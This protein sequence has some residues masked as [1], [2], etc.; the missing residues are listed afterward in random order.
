MFDV[1][2]YPSV[3]GQQDRIGFD[4]AVD[5]ALRVEEGQRL[6]TLQANGGDLLFV[7]AGVSDDIRQSAAFQVLH[8][9]PQLVADQETV[10]HFD[11]VRMMI[12]AH[13]HHLITDKKNKTKKEN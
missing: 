5:D 6:Q 8:H 7:H 13:N 9:D 11:N 2:V 12:V 3:G 4:V 1:V 10:V